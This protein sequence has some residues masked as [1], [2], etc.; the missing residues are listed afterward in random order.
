MKTVT[1]AEFNRYPSRVK[2]QALTEPVLVTDHG[3]PS[4]VVA[5]YAEWD[6]LQQKP[7]RELNGWEALRPDEPFDDDFDLM[8]FIPDRRSQPVRYWDFD[9]EDYAYLQ[10]T[11][12]PDP[13][14]TP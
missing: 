1:A 4:V 10:P 5:S 9:L 3:K 14:V 11:P 6:E 7:E 13:E 2:Q 8:D 12:S